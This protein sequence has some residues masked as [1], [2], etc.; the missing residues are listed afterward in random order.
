MAATLCGSLAGTLAVW[1]VSPAALR[2][3][4]PLLILGAALF[5]LLRRP[6]PPG[7]LAPSGAPPAPLPSVVLGLLLG[8]YDGFL[9]PGVGAFWV[10]AAMVAFHLDLLRASG[11]ARLM[12]FVSN[13]AS[14]GT[15]LA[16]G[17]VDLRTGLAMGL[18][19]ML[20]SHVGARSAIRFGAGFIRPVFVLVVMAIAGRLAWQEWSGR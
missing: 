4:V 18:S 14:L 5:V 19:L 12:N 10:T 15:F 2:R 9:G 6:R 17:L 11:V 1:V 20:G 8:F 16:L 7:A 3:I 13:L